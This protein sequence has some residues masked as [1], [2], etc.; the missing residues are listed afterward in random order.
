M[1]ERPIIFNAEMVRTILDGRKTQTRRVIKPQSPYCQLLDN[2]QLEHI[3]DGGFD[4]G[5]TYTKCPHG[6]VGDMLWVRETF[7]YR[8]NTQLGSCQLPIWYRADGI[9]HQKQWGLNSFNRGKW[10]PSIHMP[11]W[12]SRITLEITNIR[13]ERIQE[14]TEEDVT[15]E[16]ITMNNRPYAGWYWMENVYSTNSP[17]LAFEKLWDSINTKRGYGWDKNPWVWVIEF[18]VKELKQCIIKKQKNGCM[19]NGQ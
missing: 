8:E 11:R 3:P 16:G 10:K 14:I 13:V 12:A 19:A 1:K 6:K 2:G 5:L 4:W 9:S 7:A 17:L 18:K 15:A